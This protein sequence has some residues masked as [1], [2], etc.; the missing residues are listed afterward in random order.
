[1][2]PHRFTILGGIC[3]GATLLSFGAG[4]APESQAIELTER[5][6]GES[7][8]Q[9]TWVGVDG[10]DIHIKGINLGGSPGPVVR[11][12][13]W[14][15]NVTGWNDESI[16]AQIPGWILVAPGSYQL[17]VEVSKKPSTR[18]SVKIYVTIHQ[19]AVNNLPPGDPNCPQGGSAIDWNGDTTYV[20]NGATGANGANGKDGASCDPGVLAGLQAD[21]ATLQS[22]VANL[23]AAVTV[24]NLDCFPV[25]QTQNVNTGVQVTVTAGCIVGRKAT[26]GGYD[27][28][29]GPVSNPNSWY[30][31]N[32]GP[33]NLNL[34]GWSVTVKK[35]P[36]GDASA[37]MTVYSV[38][39]LL[40]K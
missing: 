12:G 5:P 11:L 33:S 2:R 40:Q 4:A 35:L 39:C 38:C 32:S 3:L 23:E 9:I 7:E 34:S 36:G 25:F 18:V 17:L 6:G 21:V 22:Q 37:N 10:Q 26:G 27:L 15:I 31:S 1:M 13:E 20:C 19:F 8:P 30:V 24:P 14:P 16:S 29:P 28:D